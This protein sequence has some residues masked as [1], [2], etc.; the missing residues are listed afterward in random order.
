MTE[1]ELELYDDLESELPIDN[2]SDTD[3]LFA[4]I[5]NAIREIKRTRNYQSHHSEDFIQNDLMNYYSNIREL[6]VYDFNQIGVEGQVS[7]SENGTN[8]SWK[9]RRECFDG[10]V[11]FCSV[12]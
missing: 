6:V 7:H 4:K 12:I 1:L 3:I 2:T 5:K 10:I 9:S 8:R 11:A